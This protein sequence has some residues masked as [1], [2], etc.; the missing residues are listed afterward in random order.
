MMPEQWTA[1]DRYICDAIVPQDA[2]LE[3]ALHVSADAGLPPISVT[4]NQGKFLH[5][6]ARAIG[7]ATSSKS[8]RWAVTARFGWRG[9]CLRAAGS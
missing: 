7:C 8:A 2:G 9:H 6:L 3:A 4:P 5:I 1:V